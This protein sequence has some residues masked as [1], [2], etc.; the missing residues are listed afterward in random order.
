MTGFGQGTDRPCVDF[1]SA[2]L[3]ISERTRQLALKICIFFDFALPDDN[4]LPAHFLKGL[5]IPAV[6]FDVPQEL[7]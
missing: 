4:D 7:G 2:N 5:D 3:V 6:A 1:A